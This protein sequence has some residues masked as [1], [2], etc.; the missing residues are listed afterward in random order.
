MSIYQFNP[1]DARRFAREQ[2]IRVRE[3]GDELQF[4]VCPYCRQTTTKKNKFAINLTNGAFNCLRASCGAKGNML[5]LARDFGFSLGRDVDEYYGRIRRY[6]D[7]SRYPRPEAKSAAVEYMEGRG[8]S[9][10]ITERYSITTNKGQDNIIVFPF[11]DEAG[12][13]Q[14]VKYRKADFDKERDSNKEWCLADCKPILFGMDQCNAEN[15]TLVMTEGQIDS[16][17]VAEAGIE[18]AVSVPTGAKGFTWV[19][20]C[21]DFLGKFETLIV[22]GDHENDRI[23]LLDEMRTRFHGSIKHVRPEDYRDCKD[24]NELLQK[25]GKQAVIDAVENAVPVKSPKIKKLSEVKRKNMSQMECITTGIRSLDRM[26]G[27]FYF[28]TLVVLTGKRGLGKSTLGSQ[29]G[30][31]AIN[32]GYPTFFYSGELMDWYFQDWFDRQCAGPERIHKD[33]ST[34]G[35]V[36]YSVKDAYADQ[37]HA[38]YDERCYIYDSAIVTEDEETETIAET[39]ESAIKQYGCRVLVVDNLMTAMD[40]DL[41]VDLYRQQTRFVNRLT[42]MAKAYDVL[43][44]LVAHP[45]KTNSDNL[46]NDDVAGSS[47]ITN[48][49]SVVLSYGEPP[50]N[51]DGTPMQEDGPDRVLTV[52]KNRLNGRVGKVGLWFEEKSKRISENG[53]YEWTLGWEGG[54]DFEPAD[55]LDGI[56][57]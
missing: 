29:F 46:E 42:E 47:N 28:G 24:A 1:E 34:L 45:R 26:I 33:E 15:K 36:S 7:L 50:K 39:M 27:G 17:S 3:K 56:P 32:S 51:K 31:F 14:F 9:R 4:T 18:N 35:Y 52:S 6:K 41:S 19:P 49:A 55:D 43:I 23:T 20:Y 21:W 54:Q 48:L 10:A 8:I 5:T 16:L 30:T 57:F 38:W 37:I 13:L 22:F 40:D 2:G 12:R 53:K 25:Y 11:Y 44:I